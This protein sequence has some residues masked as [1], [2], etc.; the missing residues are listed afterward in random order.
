LG[1]AVAW[2]LAK[3]AAWRLSARVA[4]KL[5][6]QALVLGMQMVKAS[7]KGSAACIRAAL[8]TWAAACAS[9]SSGT[10]AE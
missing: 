10:Y 7:L 5:A 2:L 6:A 1:W 4:S 3:E 8:H 9:T